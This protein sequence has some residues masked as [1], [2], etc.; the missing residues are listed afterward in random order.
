MSDFEAFVEEVHQVQ[1]CL[2]HLENIPSMKDNIE[3]TRQ[4]HSQ[5]LLTKI[6]SMPSMALVGASQLT[7]LFEHGP[8]TVLLWISIT[9]FQFFHIHS[10][11][12]CFF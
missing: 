12:I 5:T 2:A 9:P 4:S 7:G 11:P 6:A 10:F 3:G 1:T 8:W